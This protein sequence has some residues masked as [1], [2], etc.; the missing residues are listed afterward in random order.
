MLNFKQNLSTKLILL[1]SISILFDLKAQNGVGVNTN[2]PKSSFEVSGSVGKKVTVTTI[3]ITLDETNGTLVCNNSSAIAIT[4]PTASTCAARVYEIK[5][6]AGSTANVTV[7]ATIDGV[8]NYVL[9][10]AGQSVTVFSDGTNWLKRDGGGDAS[11]WSITGNTGTIAGTNFLGTTDAI[12]FVLKTSGTER[13]RALSTGNIGINET[14]PSTKLHVTLSSASASTMPLI[15]QNNG[16]GANPAGTEVVLRLSPSSSPTLRGADISALNNGLNDID[17]KF[18]TG[19]GAAPTEKV[20]IMGLGN[21]GINTSAP[22]SKLHVIANDAKTTNYAGTFLSNTATSSTSSIYKKGL[23]ITST[24]TWNGTTAANIGLHVSS[25]TGGTSNYDAI[26]NGGGYVG[27]NNIKP[28]ER[29]HVSGNIQ[30]GDS[31]ATVAT[32][33]RLEFS[34]FYNNSDPVAIYRVNTAYDNSVLRFELGDNGAGTGAG[35]DYF[36][37]CAFNTTAAPAVRIATSIGN[38]GINV[39]NPTSRLHVVASGTNLITDYAGTF[40]SNTATSTQLNVDKKGLEIT[41]TGTWTGTNS[42]NIGLHVSSV[43]GGTVNYDAIF[44]GGGF[45]GIGTATPTE[46]LHIYN[47]TAPYVLLESTGGAGKILGYKIRPWSGM[48]ANT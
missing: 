1:F 18:S 43:T 38:M 13:M 42:T 4:L 7:T 45:V 3:G 25:V 22:T 35:E 27:I 17:M 30:L 34:Q 24:G 39:L 48:A 37:F 8:I 41:S 16:G 5:R 32:G 23:E 2:T 28:R 44:N 19:S 40:L 11:N 33:N 36:D 15:V 47:G 12:D 29:L 31:M 14:S 26:F 10:Q 20:R 6:T 46:R 9:T 21:V